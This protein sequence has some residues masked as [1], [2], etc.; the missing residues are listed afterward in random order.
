MAAHNFPPFV[1]GDI[2][3]EHTLKKGFETGRFADFCII[4]INVLLTQLDQSKCRLREVFTLA[5]NFAS[6]F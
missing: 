3:V 1:V 2:D 6:H 5:L 4:R